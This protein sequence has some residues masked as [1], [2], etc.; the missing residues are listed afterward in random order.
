MPD[1]KF[2]LWNAEWMNEFFTGEPPVFVADS[3][4]GYMTKRSIGKRRNDVI[5]VINDVNSD[6]WVIVEGPNQVA[7]LQLFFDQPEVH[8]DW[9]CAV[10]PSGAQSLGL[11]VRKDPNKFE[12][13]SFD[14]YDVMASPKA[15]ALK[16][17][18]DPFQM[19]TDDDALKEY[20]KFERRP[21]YASINLAN[22]KKFRVMG[23]HLKSKGFRDALEWTKWWAKAD[24]TRK[25]IVAQCFQLRTQ[26]LDDYLSQPE[27]RNIPIIVCGDI[28][29]GPG[30]D[31]SEM[32]IQSSGIERLI[33]TVWR[34][35]LTLGNAVFD[36]LSEKDQKELDLSDLYTATF[37][38]PIF[39]YSYRRSW[40]DHI[41]YSQWKSLWVKN[42]EIIHDASS[43]EPMYREFPEAS[44]HRPVTCYI[45]MEEL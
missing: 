12:N 44:D 37:P 17:A 41:L 36:T 24:G 13:N 38:D 25:K 29:D 7:E 43:G 4:K 15:S 10:Q 21:I 16:L 32:R 11:A 45:D 42:A 8:G 3:K 14:W 5:G 30:F 33:G 39:N 2:T 31:T 23:V 40:I 27:T 28:N 22:G 34:P 19:D 35:H 20:H 18:T 1:I 26:F 9:D 6:I